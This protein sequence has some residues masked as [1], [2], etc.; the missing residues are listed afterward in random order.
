VSHAIWKIDKKT[1]KTYL[2][3]IDSEVLFECSRPSFF[4]F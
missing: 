2:L 4:N 3:S 1:G